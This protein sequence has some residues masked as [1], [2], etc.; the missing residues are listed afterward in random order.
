[1]ED[2]VFYEMTR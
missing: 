2:A 1:M